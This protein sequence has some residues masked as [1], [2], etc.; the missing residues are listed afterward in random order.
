M[1]FPQTIQSPPPLFLH[2]QNTRYCFF[3]GNFFSGKQLLEHANHIN[4]LLSDKKFFINL[5]HDRYFFAVTYLAAI[6]GNRSNLLPPNQAKITLQTLLQQYPDSICISDRTEQLNQDIFQIDKSFPETSFT[7]YSNFNPGQLVSVSFT[8]GSTGQPKAI[9]K[10]WREFQTGA[11]LAL[12]QLELENENLTIITTVPPQ[13]MFGLETGLFWPLFSKLVVESNRP[14][15]PEDI[16]EQLEQAKTPC[17]LITTPKHLK[18]CVDANLQWHNVDRIL[19]STAPLSLKLAQQVEDCF[20]APLYEI[21]G[22][23]ETLSYASR[24]ITNNPKWQP[25]QGITIRQQAKQFLISGGHLEKPVLL[26]DQF[27]LEENGQFN[28]IGR[29]TDLIKIAGKRASLLQ[30]NTLL[31]NIKEVEDGIFFTTGKERLGAF[32]VSQLTKKQILD[33]LKQ[34][35][36]P[37]FLPRPLYFVKQLPRNEVGKLVQSQLEPLIKNFQREKNN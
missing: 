13:H 25:Y 6:L 30:L 22:S 4:H 32:V 12:Q 3:R 2:L 35:I 36:D 31:L 24:R 8:S 28:V 34:S 33:V 20:N 29:S 14:F 7:A 26:N 1:S 21:F 9:S 23:T 15:F 10:T 11:K 18:S 17:L 5:C 37:V 16:R 19:C 27:Q